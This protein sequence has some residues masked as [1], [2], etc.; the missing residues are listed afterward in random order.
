MDA[1]V[2][3]VVPGVLRPSIGRAIGNVA[4]YV[5]DR[6]FPRRSAARRESCGWGAK[7]LARGY[8]G[9]P[10]LTAEKFVPDPFGGA[11]GGGCIAP[12]TWCGSSPDGSL[13]FLGRIDHQVKIRGFRV[14]LGE[15]EAALSACPG[16]QRG[17]G[18]L[19]EDLSEG[20][21]RPVGYVLARR[22]GA[23]PAGGSR[24][25]CR[26]ASGWCSRTATRPITST[27][28]SSRSA[29]Y[30]QHGVVLPR[31]A[32]IFDVGANIGMFSA[33]RRRECCAGARVYAFE[34]IVAGHFRV[35]LLPTAGCTRCGTRACSAYGLSGGERD[36][37]RF[38]YYPR[39]SDDVR[40]LRHAVPEAE[41]EVVKR[42]LE[43]LRQEGDRTPRSCSRKPT[44]SSPGV[45]RGTT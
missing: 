23:P 38:T 43:N 20:I 39:Y 34:P 8:I 32:C 4:L 18:A 29:A 21:E 5:V 19:R 7:A 30:V 33:L 22:R 13:E 6:T 12:G 11:P 25:A 26:T 17:A 42:Y 41:A 24:H 40:P 9:R 10:E 37:A 1:S 45:S 16:V 36:R 28:R 14:E 15:V 2:C 3:R 35:A 27:R 31:N 44:T